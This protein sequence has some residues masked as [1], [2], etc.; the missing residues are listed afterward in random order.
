[1]N[2]VYLGAF[3]QPSGVLK[4]LVILLLMLQLANKDGQTEAATPGGRAIL[5]TIRNKAS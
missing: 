2:R 5:I 1:M 3:P 4:T